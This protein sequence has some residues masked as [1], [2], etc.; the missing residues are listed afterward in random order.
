MVCSLVYPL[1]TRKGHPKDKWEKVLAAL[2]AKGVD[3]E[4]AQKDPSRLATILYDLDM[5]TVF[6]AAPVAPAAPSSPVKELKR[7]TTTAATTTTTTTTKKEVDK[8]TVDLFLRGL[9]VA[10]GF[11]F[12]GHVL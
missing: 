1:F 2:K 11:L 6:G 4:E 9:L 7:T 8:A 10:L 5:D 12:L 3:I